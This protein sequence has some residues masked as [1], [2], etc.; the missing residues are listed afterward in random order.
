MR[1]TNVIAP[2]LVLLLVVT[3]M[4]ASVGCGPPVTGSGNLETR[5]YDFGDFTRL[6]VSYAFDIKVTRA[7]SYSISVTADDNLFEY[8]IVSRR[9]DTLVLTM[10]SNRLYLHTTQEATITMPDLE[11]LD[12]SGASWGDVSDFSFSH[13]LD[14]ELSGASTLSIDNMKSGDA[15]FNVSGASELS[16]SIDMTEGRFD[17]SGASNIELEGEADDV[18]MD[19]SGAS[20]FIGD[21]FIVDNAN[22]E[23]SGASNATINASDTIDADLSGAS[24]LYYIGSPTLGDI[25]VS[26]ASKIRRK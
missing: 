23:L 20:R 25:D 26:G 15:T 12:L 14:I 8:V 6:D 5:E 21:D 9:G 4:M 3:S 24:S 18:R 10:R 11:R 16:G 7:S 19:V 2:V 13:E 1:A 22:I 17:I